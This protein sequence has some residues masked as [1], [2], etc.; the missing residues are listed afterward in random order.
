MKRIST[1]ILSLFLI[2]L[3]AQ[4]GLSDCKKH[5]KVSRLIEEGVF[6][7]VKVNNITPCT[8]YANILEIIPN[9]AAAKA[10]LQVGDVITKIDNTAISDQSNVFDV[11]QTYKAG[12]KIVLTYVNGE[13]TK[14]MKLRL[15]AK[16]M[17][18]VEVMECC[19]DVKSSD[20]IT[21][22]EGLTIF[23]NPASN[24]IEIRTKEALEGDT[25]I[26]IYTVEG[27]QMYYDIKNMNSSLNMKVNTNEYMN[28]SYFVRIET[29]KA[30]YTQKFEI[31]K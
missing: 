22:S 17:K 20:D 21:V 14:K 19:D 9:T 29:A 6:L 31:K 5:C 11:I 30:N 12:D 10:G 27:K 3:S 25:H 4:E 1:L 7:G 28:G 24:H 26:L 8:K 23:P 18:L 16:S 2:T 13:T 15:G